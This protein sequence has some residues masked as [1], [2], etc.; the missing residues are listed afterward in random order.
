M[1]RTPNACLA[2]LGLERYRGRSHVAVTAGQQKDRMHHAKNHDQEMECADLKSPSNE[3][4]DVCKKGL[5]RRK[6]R[7]RL[8]RSYFA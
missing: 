1:H 5:L 6:M 2:R 7:D 4:Y 8:S 3:G